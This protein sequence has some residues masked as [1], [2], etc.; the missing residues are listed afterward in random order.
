MG[1][2]KVPK[3]DLQ[4]WAGYLAVWDPSCVRPQVG[5]NVYETL[6]VGEASYQNVFIHLTQLLRV[7]SECI[8]GL[9]KEDTYMHFFSLSEIC[10]HK[11]QLKMNLQR[12]VTVW[13]SN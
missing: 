5:E 12:C 13:T 10:G 3:T 11:V 4:V 9:S 6:I 7:L 8:L 2:K 1:E